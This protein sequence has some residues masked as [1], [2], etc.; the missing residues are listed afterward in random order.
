[1]SCQ[2]PFRKKNEYLPSYL[3]LKNHNV[4]EITYP[5]QMTQ[6]NCKTLFTHL[7]SFHLRR[8]LDCAMLDVPRR[9][10]QRVLAFLAGTKSASSVPFHFIRNIN[11]PLE[12]VA[13]IMRS[14]SKPRSNP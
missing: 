9:T 1:F 2:I 4:E 14:G 8:V 5:D 7:H 3:F 6:S 11:Y 10:G 13:P 12:S